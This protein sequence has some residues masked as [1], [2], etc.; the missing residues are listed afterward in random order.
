MGC[1]EQFHI[2]TGTVTAMAFSSDGRF[3]AAGFESGSLT[4]QDLTQRS[5]PVEVAVQPGAMSAL[6]FMPDGKTLVMCR[7]GHLRRVG[8]D[9]LNDPYRVVKVDLDSGVETFL[10]ALIDLQHDLNPNWRSDGQLVFMRQWADTL[11]TALFTMDVDGAN[12]AMLLEGAVVVMRAMPKAGIVA[13]PSASRWRRA[14][15]PQD[16]ARRSGQPAFSQTMH[17]A[18]WAAPESSARPIL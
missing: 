2:G 13:A 17:S 10:S 5:R 8:E 15:R 1:G 4:V 12:Q 18:A 3:A 16:Q 9:Y 6:T 11:D 7:R 14:A